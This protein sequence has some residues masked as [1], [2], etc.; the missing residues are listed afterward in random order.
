MTCKDCKYFIAQLCFDEKSNLN[1][2]PDGE[3]CEAF[4]P[5]DLPNKSVKMI[6]KTFLPD[7]D[8]DQ[9]IEAEKKLFVYL[10]N[11]RVIVEQIRNGCMHGTSG[12]ARLAYV[13]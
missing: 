8:I 9:T 10:N 5:A 1:T 7:A 4:T 13:S 6:L 2:N 11:K 3:A 12:G